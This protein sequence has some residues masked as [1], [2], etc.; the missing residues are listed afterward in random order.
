[1]SR[2]CLDGAAGDV[3]VSRQVSSPSSRRRRRAHNDS[4]SDDDDGSAVGSP[5]AVTGPSDSAAVK[6]LRRPNNCIAN[7]G[8]HA[9]SLSDLWTFIRKSDLLISFVIN[10]CC[11]FSR[12]SLRYIR[13]VMSI[14]IANPCVVCT[15]FD[16]KLRRDSSEGNTLAR[17][18]QRKMQTS[19]VT[20][21]HSPGVV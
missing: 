2:R 9:F 16:T 12:T 6:A 18:K 4:S 15:L 20:I 7:R 17:E 5:R 14:V 10:I 8:L 3:S 19:D 11:I 13:L 1:M 21:R